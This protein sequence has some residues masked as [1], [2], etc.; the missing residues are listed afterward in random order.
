[1]TFQELSDLVD[2]LKKQR[3][4]TV[5]RVNSAL[6]ELATTQVERD[7]LRRELC[8]AYSEISELKFELRKG[9][10]E[11][12]IDDSSPSSVPDD[13]CALCDG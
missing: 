6:A 8:R 10:N 2:T 9:I 4:K 13:S 12:T 3:N 5:E 1:M 11:T 7:D